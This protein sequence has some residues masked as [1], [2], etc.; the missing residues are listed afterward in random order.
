VEEIV[1]ANPGIIIPDWPAPA[2]VKAAVTTRKGGVSLPP[3]DS[4]NLASHVNDNP[5]HVAQNRVLLK[6]TLQLPNEPLWLNQTH[7]N[8]VIHAGQHKP[9]IEADACIATEPGHVCAV[10]T[11]DCLPILVCNKQGTRVQAIHA[12]WQGIAK[13]VIEA[14]IAA[15]PGEKTDLLVYLGPAIG[16]ES[17]EVQSDVVEACTADL[18]SAQKQMFIK[19]CFKPVAGK[20]G[21]YL[22]DLYELGRQRLYKCGVTQVY[23][24]NFCTYTDRDRFY[25]YRRDGK[26]GTGKTGRMASLIWLAA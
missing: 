12:G 8:I 3:Y 5:E 9:G 16:P 24:G 7:S 1:M 6:H 15:Y 17:F 13:R 22:G 10:L 14:S 19:K 21:H 23:G 20:E 4:F 2:Q 11:A 26:I 18:T 25:S